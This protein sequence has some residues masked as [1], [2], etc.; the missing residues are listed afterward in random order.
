[1]VHYGNSEQAKISESHY[2]KLRFFSRLLP[3]FQLQ[4]PQD[5]DSPELVRLSLQAQNL[6]LKKQKTNEQKNP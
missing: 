3:S 1:M 6:R 5:Q 4:I 2:V